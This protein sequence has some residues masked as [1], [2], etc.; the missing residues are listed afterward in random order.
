MVDTVSFAEAVTMAR[1]EPKMTC[2]VTQ[3]RE[4]APHGPG[5]LA[6]ARLRHHRRR[7]LFASQ[8][9]IIHTQRSAGRQ[10]V[11]G[12]RNCSACMFDGWIPVVDALPLYFRTY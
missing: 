9:T 10:A 6:A 11:S 12:Q 3:P 1:G 7:L 5:S 2:R 8:Q 4:D